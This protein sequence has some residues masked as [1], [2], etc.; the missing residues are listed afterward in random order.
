MPYAFKFYALEEAW[1]AGSDSLLW[2]DASLCAMRSRAPV[3]QKR[4]DDG[5]LLMQCHTHLMGTWSTDL[6][7]STLG[8]TREQAFERVLIAGGLFGIR[9]SSK[10]GMQFFNEVKTLLVPEIMCGDWN[11]NRKQCS[12][13]PRVYGH[14]HDQVVLG[15][16][17]HELRLP[18][19]KPPMFFDY[20]SKSAAPDKSTVFVVRGV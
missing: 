4:E 5:V 20:A 13:D 1:N 2:G 19:T 8:I 14:R 7:L 15:H 16:V 11:N 10:I 18:V 17:A 9:K 3:W 6:S 12:E